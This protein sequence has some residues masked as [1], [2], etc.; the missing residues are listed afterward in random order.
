MLAKKNIES[1]MWEKES[2]IL[3]PTEALANR[4]AEILAA[5]L[6][7]QKPTVVIFR[8]FD[9]IYYVPGVLTAGQ[10]PAWLGSFVSD[11]ISRLSGESFEL[12]WR[13][14]PSANEGTI[15]SA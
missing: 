7:R 14:E 2:F 3:L 9:E 4:V 12:S 15:F 5:Q 10:T 13:D 6:P 11:A 8:L 1:Q